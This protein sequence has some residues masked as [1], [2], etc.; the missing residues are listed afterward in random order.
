LLEAQNAI[1]AVSPMVAGA[2]LALRGEATQ[3]I[4]LMG[5]ELDRYDRVVG[6]RAKVVSGSARLS[7]ARPS[8]AATW[9]RTW[10]CAWATA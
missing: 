1:A 2:G 3:A 8:W 9:R 5:V 10:A 7:P 4:S 6:L